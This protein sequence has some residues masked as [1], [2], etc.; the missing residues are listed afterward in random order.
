MI[1]DFV[2]TT[3]VAYSHLNL[4]LR[5]VTVCAKCLGPRSEFWRSVF[6]FSSFFHLIVVC[7]MYFLLNERMKTRYIEIK[8]STLL[9]IETLLFFFRTP[10]TTNQ[11][12][13]W[14]LSNL[15]WT[16]M[17]K[18]TFPSSSLAPLLS[19]I[20]IRIFLSQVSTSKLCKSSY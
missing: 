10:M 9:N 3:Y 2:S 7:F 19:P 4:I 13:R 20:W 17:V 14:K 12:W 15:R 1:N 16:K 18:V 11:V 6:F 5:I 8:L